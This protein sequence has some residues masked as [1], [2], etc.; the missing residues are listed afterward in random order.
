MY[1]ILLHTLRYLHNEQ[2]MCLECFVQ[3]CLVFRTF[4]KFTFF[5]PSWILSQGTT[6][7]S[8]EHLIFS[9]LCTIGDQAYKAVL[10]IHVICHISM[11]QHT[12][13]T[14]CTCDTV[15][16]ENWKPKNDPRC[17]ASPYT[18]PSRRF[19][20]QECFLTAFFLVCFG[21]DP[22]SLQMLSLR[23]YIP[24]ALYFNVTFPT[25][26]TC[27]LR[28]RQYVPLRCQSGCTRKCGGLIPE[29]SNLQQNIFFT[30]RIP[31]KVS[32]SPNYKYRRAAVRNREAR[33]KLDGW[34]CEQCKNVSG[35]HYY[36]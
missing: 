24:L 8:L 15:H 14:F 4:W 31:E 11:Q 22:V 16:T 36:G 29:G 17:S 2:C 10:K 32:T 35:G 25:L 3:G 1:K 20:S 19:P 23:K 26:C 18:M 21:T 13:E 12:I 27:N 30:F 7:L 33:R 6:Y 34:E 5:L 28:W 9:P